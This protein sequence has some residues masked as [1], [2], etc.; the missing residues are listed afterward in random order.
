[1]LELGNHELDDL[2][3]PDLLFQHC[4][5]RRGGDGHD[6]DQRHDDDVF[7]EWAAPKHFVIPSGT[8]TSVAAG[9]FL[10]L[11]LFSLDHQDQEEE[12]HLQDI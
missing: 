7:D 12:V 10:K 2:D 8:V 5:R 1:M 6:L 4:H 11:A 3:I 9:P